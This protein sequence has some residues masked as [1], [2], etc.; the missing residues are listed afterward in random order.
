M[1][2]SIYSENRRGIYFSL[3]RTITTWMTNNYVSL[4]QYG[5]INV[6]TRLTLTLF[7]AMFKFAM[8]QPWNIGL[9]VK[10]KKE[11]NKKKI[12]GWLFFIRQ[13]DSV[14]KKI[15]KSVI[16][17]LFS[18]QTGYIMRHSRLRITHVSIVI[19]LGIDLVFVR[20]YLS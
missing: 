6:L 9:G 1:N 15:V 7:I 4:N 3:P 8:V 2:V 10:T 11:N 19:V 5:I 13:L 20:N 12:H 14:L 18:Y 17:L 16:Y